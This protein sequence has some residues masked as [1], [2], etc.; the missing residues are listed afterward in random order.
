MRVV[1]SPA[2]IVVGTAEKLST[3]GGPGGAGFTVTVTPELAVPP[4]PVA[5]S[6]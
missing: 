4:A 3:L 6:V 2:V 1:E 5:T